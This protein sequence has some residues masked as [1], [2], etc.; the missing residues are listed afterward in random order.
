MAGARG[1][2]KEK[3]VLWAHNGRVVFGGA[4]YKSTGRGSAN[5]SDASI[6]CSVRLAARRGVRHWL[7]QGQA[8]RPRHLSRERRPTPAC[9]SPDEKSCSVAE[10][11]PFR[12]RVSDLKFSRY[13]DRI[14]TWCNVPRLPKRLEL[15][16]EWRHG[17]APCSPGSQDSKTSC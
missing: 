2:P 5:G 10:K 3:I 1:A 4:G 9:Y 6:T 11:Q 14:H 13:C 12:G 17:G 7:H 8:L 16:L 15:H